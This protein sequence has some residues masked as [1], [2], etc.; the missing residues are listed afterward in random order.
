MYPIQA[1][2]AGKLYSMNLALLHDHLLHFEDQPESSLEPFSQLAR[3]CMHKNQTYTLTRSP[4]GWRSSMILKS[5][6][7]PSLTTSKK[8]GS[9]E[10]YCTNL[11]SKGMKI[12][13]M[14]GGK[15]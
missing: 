12:D 5:H 14:N 6:P 11:R 10:K 1:C 2:I 15:W 3:S 9:H 8:L 7:P 4:P 13:I